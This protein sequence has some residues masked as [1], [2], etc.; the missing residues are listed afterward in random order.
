MEYNFVKF[1]RLCP[2]LRKNISSLLTQFFCDTCTEFDVAAVIMTYR[3][4]K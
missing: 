1:F 3:T 2:D 4:T